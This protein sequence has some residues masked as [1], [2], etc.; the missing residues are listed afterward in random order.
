[1]PESIFLLTGDYIELIKLLKVLNI[2]ESGAHAKFLVNSG[3]IIVN[4]N[5]EFRK[6]CKLRRGDNVIFE[7]KSIRIK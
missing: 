4:R 7:D 6:R 2:A 5:V 1:M 3:K